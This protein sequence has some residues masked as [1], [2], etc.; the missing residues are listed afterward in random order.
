MEMT[1]HRQALIDAH[2]AETHTL[3]ADYA[4]ELNDLVRFALSAAKEKGH[5]TYY[6]MDPVNEC[7]RN[8]QGLSKKVAKLAADLE[9]TASRLGV[10]P[11]DP[12]MPAASDSESPHN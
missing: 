7:I 9:K 6:P 4:F 12:E 8:W 11:F 5:K 2:V 3:M 1:P 10:Q